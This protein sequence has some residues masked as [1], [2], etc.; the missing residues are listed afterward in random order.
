MTGD[1][2]W[3]FSALTAVFLLF[4]LLCDGSVPDRPPSP[5]ALRSP[6]S[7]LALRS[8]RSAFT[9]PVSSRPATSASSPASPLVTPVCLAPSII[10]A[11]SAASTA[12]SGRP[13]APRQSVIF[14]AHKDGTAS[15][16]PPAARPAPSTT[17]PVSIAPRPFPLLPVLSVPAGSTPL[18]L[19]PGQVIQVPPQLLAS[20]AQPL[21]AQT[22][23][24]PDR[25]RTYC[26]QH[27]GC[28][29]TYFKSSHLK[30]H[31]RTH[32]GECLAV[33]PGLAECLLRLG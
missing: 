28:D 8:P 21:T 2:S 32:T 26:C 18:L 12:P 23:A 19:T 17:R 3:C 29:K 7:P 14:R 24:V 9:A 15:P 20:A 33:C 31:V 30:A 22:P 6:Q 27:A 25:K 16:H 10:A 11:P 5:L 1:C 4:Q 13:A